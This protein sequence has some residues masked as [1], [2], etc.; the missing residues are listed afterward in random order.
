[1]KLATAEP[2]LGRKKSGRKT[3]AVK[4]DASVAM[5][6]AR[7]AEDRGEHVSDLLTEM[8][9]ERVE[10]EW[11]RIVKRAADVESGEG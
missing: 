8:V 6:L 3:A 1:M 2:A 9:R 11:L 4:I 7:I 10:R 5:K